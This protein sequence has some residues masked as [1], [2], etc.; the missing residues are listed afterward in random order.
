MTTDDELIKTPDGDRPWKEVRR[1]LAMYDRQKKI[2]A[3]EKQRRSIASKKG[4][5][6]RKAQ[7]K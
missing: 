4:W 1:A 7:G 2:A 5:E 3:E 6:K